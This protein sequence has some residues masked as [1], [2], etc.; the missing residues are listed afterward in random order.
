M[1]V[2][3][4]WRSASDLNLLSCLRLVVLKQS[5]KASCCTPGSRASGHPILISDWVSSNL[6]PHLGALQ[7]TQNGNK[8][9][10]HLYCLLLGN[11]QNLHPGTLRSVHR[12]SMC[13]HVSL[14]A[15]LL[16]MPAV[17]SCGGSTT[18]E[19]CT[20]PHHVWWIFFLLTQ[21]R[22]LK[23]S[24]AFERRTSFRTAWTSCI[25]SLKNDWAW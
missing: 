5:T 18:Q 6:W 22:C 12:I 2:A 15:E 19:I 14:W 21:S 16:L 3:T 7:V 25:S 1:S 24:L 20:H 9:V 4:C 8:L 11:Q 23:A 13:V 17:S 10:K